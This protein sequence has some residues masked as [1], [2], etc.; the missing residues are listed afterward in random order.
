[1]EERGQSVS[2]VPPE[3]GCRAGSV[4]AA[5]VVDT[6]LTRHRFTGSCHIRRADDGGQ[7]HR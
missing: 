5:V 7:C 2:V 4:L 6:L 1:M 3:T